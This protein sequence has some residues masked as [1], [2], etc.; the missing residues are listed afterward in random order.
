M[1]RGWLGGRQNGQRVRREI[2]NTC[3]PVHPAVTAVSLIGHREHD[4]HYTRLR[5]VELVVELNA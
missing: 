1:G 3:H 4:M 2:A 5:G